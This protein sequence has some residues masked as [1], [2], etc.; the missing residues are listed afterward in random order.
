LQNEQHRKII[1][2][3]D[4]D[5]SQTGYY[6]ITICTHNQKHIL[7]NIKDGKMILNEYA[8]K[9]DK[10]LNDIIFKIE[11]IS[12]DIYVFMPNHIHL[13]IIIQNDNFEGTMVATQNKIGIFEF[14]RDFK[15]LSTM[16]YIDG[17]KNGLYEPYDKML[18][19][20][21]YYDKV[22]R[23]NQ[24]YEKIYEYIE[25]NPLKWEIDKYYRID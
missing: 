14:V 1:R 19:Q 3:K 13:I 10:V 25:N 21:S 9:V 22:I 20:R 11:D 4:Y 16:I 5:Y 18:W 8:E 24:T 23:D 7:G 17:V 12:L 2:I 15:S 6:F